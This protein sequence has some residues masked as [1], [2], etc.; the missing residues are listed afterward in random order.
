[1]PYEILPY[2][3]VSALRFGMT[4]LQIHQILGVPRFSRRDAHRLREMH[5]VGGPALTFKAVAGS[6][7]S[8][9][10]EIG[11]TRAATDVIYRGTNLF[12]GERPAIVTKLYS[13]DSEPK[14]VSGTLVFPKLG[15]TLTGF[16][17]GPEESMAVTAFAPG[18]WD[19][20]LVGA[21]LS[22]LASAS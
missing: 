15:I 21:K 14:E 8:K 1:M 12:S 9:L 16:H 6:E 19:T 4:S 17:S 11:F 18:I 5:G 10:A 2:V 7:E 3:G 22:S 20:N 13:D